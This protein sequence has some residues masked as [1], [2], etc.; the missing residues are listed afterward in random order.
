MGTGPT[1]A[2]KTVGIGA[3][4]AAPTGTERP[5]KEKPAR[6]ASGAEVHIGFSAWT[7]VLIGFSVLRPALLGAEVRIGFSAT[8]EVHIGFS[9]I[10]PASLEAEVHIGFSASTRSSQGRFQEESKSGRHQQVKII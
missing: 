8:T 3:A 5:R 7:E 1:G 6:L 4:P 2:T 9:V 10:R